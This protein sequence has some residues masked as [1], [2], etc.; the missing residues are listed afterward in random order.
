MNK[1]LPLKNLASATA[2]IIKKKSE[3]VIY[4]KAQDDELL[5]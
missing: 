1:V 5:I 3:K 4:I 2:D